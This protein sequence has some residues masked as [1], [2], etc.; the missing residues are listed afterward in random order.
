MEQTQAQFKFIA[1]ENN[2][3]ILKVGQRVQVRIT[4][5]WTYS[6]HEFVV[7]QELSAQYSGGDYFNTHVI[8]IVNSLLIPTSHLK[9]LSWE[10]QK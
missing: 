6:E 9:I 10:I 1:E 4:E 5:P 2:T 8:G 7:G 3:K